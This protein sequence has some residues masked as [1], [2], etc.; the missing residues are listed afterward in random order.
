MEYFVLEVGKK[1]VQPDI[2]EFYGKIDKRTLDLTGKNEIPPNLF[3]Y[4]HENMQMVATSI[5][6][7]PTF[8]V[9]REMRE[10]ILM[11]QRGITFKR[12]IL[13]SKER[14]ESMTY[15]L[16]FLEEID[17][18]LEESKQNVKKGLYDSLK[19]D[20]NKVKGRALISVGGLLTS[21]ILVRMDL[22][23]SMLMRNTIGIEVKETE[24]LL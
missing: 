13:Y 5:M 7:F 4:V 17:C 8:M 16:P 6:T 24:V 19:I 12:I 15:Y 21:C 20:G 10:V 14:K 23:E 9:N 1:Y 18:L 2:K 3:L 11:Y 22:L